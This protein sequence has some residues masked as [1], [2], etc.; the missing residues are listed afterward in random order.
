MQQASFS[1]SNLKE[2]WA[3][4][5]K[6]GIRSL[7]PTAISWSTI[8]QIDQVTKSIVSTRK[9]PSMNK[10]VPTDQLNQGVQV[11]NYCILPPMLPEIPGLL[12]GSIHSPQE[13]G[14]CQLPP[15]TAGLD[16]LPPPGMEL[17]LPT[18]RT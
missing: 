7:P 17:I 1:G 2:C 11:T 5:M 14:T 10:K 6:H 3:W 16:F 18:Q 15:A 9:L 13:N 4:V 12:T 8:V